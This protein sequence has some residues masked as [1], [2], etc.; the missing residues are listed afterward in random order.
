MTAQATTRCRCGQP[1][2]AVWSPVLR[3]RLWFCKASGARPIACP[4]AA[5]EKKRWTDSLMEVVTNT[6]RLEAR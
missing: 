1:L 6:E 5:T 3:K 4:Y 2:E